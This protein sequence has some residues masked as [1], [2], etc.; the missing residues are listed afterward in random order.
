MVG[1][2][3]DRIGVDVVDVR[4]RQEGVQQGLDRRSAGT[5]IE[6]SARDKVGHLLIGHRVEGAQRLELVEAQTRVVRG[7]RATH[8]G[9]GALHPHHSLLTPE[10][11]GHRALGR[12]VASAVDHERRIIAYP[13]GPR[14][15]LLQRRHHA[16]SVTKAV[17]ATTPSGSTTACSVTM[18]LI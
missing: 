18:A 4:K 14:D 3:A 12:G 1:Q 13:I 9:P 8:V 5:R 16:Y 11:I 17:T 2:C 6:Q 7:H 15:E 10:V